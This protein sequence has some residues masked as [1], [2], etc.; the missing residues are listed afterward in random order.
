MGD[1]D[2]ALRRVRSG[3]AARK[4]ETAGLDFKMPSAKVK[5]TLA[6]LAE[7]AVCFANAAGG[8][9]VV[10]VADD[11]PGPE[12]LVGS[13]I[14]P[15]T[16]RHGVYERTVPSLDVVVSRFEFA[17]VHLLRIDVPEGIEVVSSSSGRYSWR[18]GTDCLPMT[19]DDVGRLR[20]ERRGK[21]WSARS[22]RIDA[23]E[24]VDHAALTRVRE[25][26]DTVTTDG[27]RALRQADDRELLTGLGLATSRGKLSNAGDSLVGRRSATGEPTIVYQHRR[28]AAGEADTILHLQ[29]PLIVAMQR[30]LEAIELRLRAT[31]LNLTGGQQLQVQDF[32]MPA[33]RE[34]VMNAVAHGDHRSGRPIQVEHS[35]DFL[36]ITSP[37]PLVAGVTPENILRHPHRARFR[38]LFGALRHLGLVE[39]VGLGVD[40]M[41]REMLRVGRNP[42][43]I[44]EDRDQVSVTFASDE[45][46]MRVARFVNQLGPERRD[47][48][49][50]LQ[51]LAILR[52][53]RSVAAPA[54]AQVIQRPLT[55]TQTLLRR[56]GDGDPVARGH[57]GNRAAAKPELPAPGSGHRRAGDRG[58]LSPCAER[59]ARSEDRRARPGVRHDQQQDGAEPLRRRCL[60]GIGDPPRAGGS[61][62]GRE[63][64]GADTGQRRSVRPGLPVPRAAP[65]PPSDVTGQ[66]V[67]IS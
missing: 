66:Q 65:A 50:V 14:E 25:L 67:R 24:G 9:I 23:T 18:R 57:T 7:A 61:R 45:P 64:L 21:D 46:N 34:A 44:V 42:P 2:T 47:D 29:G 49:D 10:G 32:P 48:L 43:R 15:E 6:N 40:R 59:R 12:A 31:P 37:G 13:T 63:D 33:L 8:T 53:R 58:R 35:P 51:V 55:D 20:E 16:I 4:L 3:T 22:S 19:A 28:A 17:D 56:L 41:Y 39:Q 62:A 11:V 38:A 52:Q 26:L 36:T 54:V 1:V 30:R 60:P 27:A 5:D